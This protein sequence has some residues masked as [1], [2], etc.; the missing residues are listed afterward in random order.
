MT[1]APFL[2][3][4]LEGMITALVKALGSPTR[5]HAM[6]TAVRTSAPIEEASWQVRTIELPGIEHFELL[7]CV[8]TKTGEKR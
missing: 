8:R 3:R 2:Q 1:V 6:L 5:L 7:I 4:H